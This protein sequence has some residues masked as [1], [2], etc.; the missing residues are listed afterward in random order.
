MKKT[1]LGIL[2]LVGVV[3]LSACTNNDKQA[4][5]LPLVNEEYSVAVE[6][7]DTTTA[8]TIVTSEA[9][10]TEA[11]TESSTAEETIATIEEVTEKT[12]SGTG[13]AELLDAKDLAR[14]Y[15]AVIMSKITTDKANKSEDAQF[16]PLIVNDGGTGLNSKVAF[17]DVDNDAKPELIIG[18]EGMNGIGIY[19][20][21][22]VD[23]SI[24]ATDVCCSSELECSCVVNGILYLYGGSAM[25]PSCVQM[26]PGTPSIVAMGVINE[27]DAVNDIEVHKADGTTESFEDLT[28]VEVKAVYQQYLDVNY[29]ELNF[30]NSATVPKYVKDYLRLE[31][32]DYTEDD[33]YNSILPMLEKYVAQ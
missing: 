15:A 33:I 24:F 19:D 11:I 32:A 21:Y 22:K 26:L 14:K 25:Y 16:Q 9:M 28:Y 17:M 7:T 10:I 12:L 18:C 8:E 30:V 27:D 13:T 1:L 2:C 29:E 4:E 6:Q 3:V 31:T 20:I 23:G 5:T